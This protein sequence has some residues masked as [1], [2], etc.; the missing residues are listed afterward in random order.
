MAYQFIVE[1]GTGIPDANSYVTVEEAD[2]YL[3]QNIHVEAKWT[4]LSLDEK[5]RLLSWA[6]RYLDQHAEWNGYPTYPTAQL[7]WPRMFVTNRD[8]I[9]ISQ[10]TIP[11]Q[12]KEATMELARYLLTDDL[13]EPRAQDGLKQ[14]KV[15]VIEIV[16]NADYRLPKIPPELNWLLT[17][18]GFLKG[19]PSSYAKIRRA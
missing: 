5:Q 6:S 18:L 17:G 16:F 4:A 1:D 10:Y 13:S 3:T 8:R 15:D 2:D 11:Q 12:I 7:R 9:P 19:G 14:V